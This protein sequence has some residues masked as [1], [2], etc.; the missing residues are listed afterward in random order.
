MNTSVRRVGQWA[1]IVAVLA[2]FLPWATV[3]VEVVGVRFSGA[4]SA[5]GIDIG[6]IAGLSYGWAM[7]G[8]ACASA[9]AF[10]RPSGWLLFFGVLTGVFGLYATLDAVHHVTLV[11]GVAGQLVN[12]LLKPH[13]AARYGAYL[14]GLAACTILVA[15]IAA[16]RSS[17]ADTLAETAHRSYRLD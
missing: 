10:A 6:S 11:P 15:A 7:I 2:A 17:R 12:A 5:K 9:L 8:L 4:A 16:Y 13:V 14:E 1:A 3:S